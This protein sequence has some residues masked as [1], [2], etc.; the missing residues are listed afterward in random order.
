MGEKDK[1]TEANQGVSGDSL[2]LMKNQYYKTEKKM[3]NY[4]TKIKN[5]YNSNSK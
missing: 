4:N 2:E 1:R 5:E 3:N